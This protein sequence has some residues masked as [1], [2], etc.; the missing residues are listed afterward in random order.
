MIDDYYPILGLPALPKEQM[1]NSKATDESL[2]KLREKYAN[3]NFKDSFSWVDE[4]V[5][6]SVKDQRQCGS[7]TAFACTGAVE[8]CCAI[9]SG[10]I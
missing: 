1:K 3:Y 4:G 9:V 6:T 2:K 5:V 7:C 8:S 10:Q